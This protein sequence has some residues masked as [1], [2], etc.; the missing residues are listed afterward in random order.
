VTNAS[1]GTKKEKVVPAVDFKDCLRAAC[2]RPPSLV[3]VNCC[4]GETGGVLGV[5]RQLSSFIPAVV[6]NCTSAYIQAARAQA[7]TFWREALI[8]GA[9]PHEAVAAVRRAAV[10]DHGLTFADLRWLVPTLRVRYR[11]WSFQ[12]PGREGRDRDDVN[13]EHKLDRTHQFGQVLYR[14]RMLMDEDRHRLLACVWYGR[15]G[16][17]LQQFHERLHLELPAHVEEFECHRVKPHWPEQWLDFRK[18]AGGM[19]AHALGAGNASEIAQKIAATY[20]TEK[21]ILLYVDHTTIALDQDED[22]NLFDVKRLRDY[23][24]WLDQ[25]FARHLPTNVV[26]LFGISFVTPSPEEFRNAFVGEGGIIEIEFDRLRVELLAEMKSL[27]WEDLLDFIRTHDVVWPRDVHRRRQ[28]FNDLVSKTE[29]VYEQI[30]PAILA[31]DPY[32]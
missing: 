5:G 30:L 15:R 2:K 8:E 11:N 16:Q 13:W 23:F 27:E 18:T 25:T 9:A 20:G 12:P 1:D 4:M 19:L 22:K 17:G 29:G 32:Q 26:A 31:V 14:T 6:T 21:N 7:M 3:Y 10:I 28:L 24:D